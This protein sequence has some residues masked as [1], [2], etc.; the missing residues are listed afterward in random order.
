MRVYPFTSVD[1]NAI[2]MFSLDSTKDMIH[3]RNAE[4]G[5]DDGFYFQGPKC[6][7]G[8]DVTMNDTTNFRVPLLFNSD[9][10]SFLDML[11]RMKKHIVELL[12][13]KKDDFFDE[14]DM[15][16]TSDVKQL[17]NELFV[18]PYT[19]NSSKGTIKLTLLC[20]PRSNTRWAKDYKLVAVDTEGNRVQLDTITKFTQILP[21]INVRGIQTKDNFCIEFILNKIIVNN[22]SKQAIPVAKEESVNN[23]TN[24]IT[25]E[26]NE[27]SIDTLDASDCADFKVKQ[28]K[29]LYKKWVREFQ[30]SIIKS[31]CR[32]LKEW[33]NKQNIYD[34]NILLEVI[35]DEIDGGNDSGGYESQ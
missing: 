16:Q 30:D 4:G 24:E 9:N 11:V 21:I 2:R 19:I 26:I 1:L 13:A 23:T 34:S 12:F 14:E 8:K 5:D 10:V 31:K 25:G 33:M 7:I 15:K 22:M 6:H 18:D 20:N 17:I 32:Y 28:P 27:I 3:I 35:E 29:N